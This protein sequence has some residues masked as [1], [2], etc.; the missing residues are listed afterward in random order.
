[1]ANTESIAYA[2][3]ND[4][5]LLLQDNKTLFPIDTKYSLEEIDFIQFIETA[6]TIIEVTDTFNTFARLISNYS[7]FI[8]RNEARNHNTFVNN[9]RTI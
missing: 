3:I 1:M 2:I 5:K 4:F 7:F 8:P 6:K 9:F